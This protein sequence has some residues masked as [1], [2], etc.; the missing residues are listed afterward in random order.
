MDGS[1]RLAESQQT[2]PTFILQQDSRKK[3]RYS[4]KTTVSGVYRVA[5]AGTAKRGEEC[6]V[7]DSSAKHLKDDV[8]KRLTVIQSFTSPACSTGVRSQRCCHGTDTNGERGAVGD[9]PAKIK[10]PA[11]T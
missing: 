10:V 11:K 1:A 3:R 2:I 7:G 5:A 6:G 8:L 4:L 9:K